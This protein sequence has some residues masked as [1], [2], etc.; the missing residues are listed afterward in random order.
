MIAAEQ[1]AQRFQRQDARVVLDVDHKL[2]WGAKVSAYLVT[3]GIGAG[4]CMW[5][6]FLLAMNGSALAKD[7]APELIGIVFTT[8]TT[9][10]LVADLKRP[11]LF[12]TLLLRPNWKSWLVKGAIVLIAFSTITA[13]IVGARLLGL[14]AIANGL[15]WTNVLPA[16]MAAAYTAFLFA[17]CEGRDL[18]Q[19][20]NVLLPHL[21][22]QALWV[23][24]A[25]LLPFIPDRGL[26]VAVAVLAIVH[27]A[28]GLFERF[29]THHTSNAQQAAAMLAEVKA[30]PGSRHSALHLGLA[31]GT[32]SAQLSA[33]WV[34]SGAA[35]PAALAM[36][37]VLAWAGLF[38]Y[39]QAYVRAGQLPPLS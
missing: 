18:W 10:L 19:R 23:G 14:D 28:L 4:A 26:A 34:V 11:K 24:G 16:S 29:S 7:Y 15:R 33:F 21:L 1:D 3:K 17:Q 32:A 22:V 20:T 5:A 8:L 39:E 36:C 27:H 6:P 2:H 35:H 12:L 31:T 9:I 37:A 38:L 30:W 25:A 13:A